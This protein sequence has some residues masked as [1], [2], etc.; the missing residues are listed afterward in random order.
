MVVS[1]LEYVWIDFIKFAFTSVLCTS[2]LLLSR[3]VWS[4]DPGSDCPPLLVT[5][6]AT[7]QVL[8]PVLGP[9]VQERH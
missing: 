5:G 4:A 3:I 6:E 7:P 9:S 1:S 8:Y 2:A